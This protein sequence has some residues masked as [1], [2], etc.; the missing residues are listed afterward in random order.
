MTMKYDFLR[1]LINWERKGKS[2]ARVWQWIKHIQT[3][4]NINIKSM[5]EYN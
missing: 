3:M 4:I 5:C 2:A 1:K